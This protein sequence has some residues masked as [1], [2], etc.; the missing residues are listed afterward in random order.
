[1]SILGCPKNKQKNF[2]L[3]AQCI[4][5]FSAEAESTL[6][7]DLRDCGSSRC[8]VPETTSFLSCHNSVFLLYRDCDHGYKTGTCLCG[9]AWHTDHCPA[10]TCHPGFK[11]E[12]RSASRLTVNECGYRS[13]H[14][15]ALSSQSCRSVSMSWCRGAP[16]PHSNN[17]TTISKED[18]VD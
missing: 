10:S 1:M 6:T 13:H 15:S 2:F 18:L 17:H 3:P 8:L 7:E 16:A 5:Y 12:P 11:T 4:F 14:L 9:S